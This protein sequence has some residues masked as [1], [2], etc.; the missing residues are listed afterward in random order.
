MTMFPLFAHGPAV[1]LPETQ[2]LGVQILQM[3]RGVTEAL[4]VVTVL[5]PDEGAVKLGQST[6]PNAAIKGVMGKSI[7][8]FPSLSVCLEQHHLRY[9]FVFQCSSSPSQV[10]AQ[11]LPT[12]PSPSPSSK[13][14][15]ANKAG[16]LPESSTRTVR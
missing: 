10:S 2:K 13:R 4:Q 3:L 9:N 5:P 8:E 12:A 1:S 6:Q 11:R 16:S 14:L 15:A 7:S